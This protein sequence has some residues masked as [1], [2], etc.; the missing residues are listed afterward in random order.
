ME[1]NPWNFLHENK[2]QNFAL[3]LNCV[4]IFANKCQNFGYENKFVAFFAW[5]QILEFLP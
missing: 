4:D 5:K 1:T 3:E 2:Y